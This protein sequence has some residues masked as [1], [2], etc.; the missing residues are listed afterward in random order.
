M[1]T[2]LV[3]LVFLI[4]SFFSSVLLAN[5][6]INEFSAKEESIVGQMIEIA[7]GGNDAVLDLTIR[8]VEKLN[9]HVT[10]GGWLKCEWPYSPNLCSQAG[11]IPHHDGS[12]CFRIDYTQP[13]SKSFSIL[14][15]R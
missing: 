2:K 14:D 8:E 12:C 3:M 6:F 7:E 10:G 5:E 1:N 15:P 11:W 4:G 13:P 9:C